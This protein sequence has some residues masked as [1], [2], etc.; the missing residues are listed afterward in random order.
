[1]EELVMPST[2]WRV[3]LSLLAVAI[4]VPVALLAAGKEPDKKAA[5]KIT[6]AVIESYPD[7]VMA[8]L[9][10]QAKEEQSL[11][12]VEGRSPRYVFYI[13][14]LWTPGQ[15]VRVAFKGGTPALHADIAKAAEQWTK[16]ANLF[17]DF[18][19]DRSTQTYRTWSADDKE[20]KAEIR[21]G[22]DQPGYWSLIGKACVNPG[23]AGPGRASMNFSGFDKEKPWNFE[24]V[25][26]H[27]FGH[28][29][30]FLHEHQHPKEGCDKEFRWDDDAGYVATKNASG[31]Y[32]EDTSGKRPGLNTVL[33]GPPNN[34][35]KKTI[36]INLQ[37]WHYNE[38][39]YD[40][41]FSNFDK[42]SIMKYYFDA[43]MFVH[44]ESSPCY[45]SGPN[46]KLSE[47]DKEGARKNYPRAGRDVESALEE[48]QRLLKA[49]AGS[50]GLSGDV[51]KYLEDQLKKMK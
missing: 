26:L 27:E 40:F 50:K 19:F 31:H 22:F 15:T 49:A 6:H 18:G 36:Q 30:G 28:A 51:K 24:G 4:V 9:K 3:R 37:Q 21:I 14:A 33:S 45:T 44:G 13:A 41:D 1:V 39:A 35:D 29:L 20:Y 42:D 43:W 25:V 34:W 48:R 8:G 46:V 5:P 47:K 10:K 17:F 23:V 7:W 32:V 2:N 38:R 12:A 16:E 11:K